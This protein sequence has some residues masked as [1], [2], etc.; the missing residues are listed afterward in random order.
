MASFQIFRRKIF[1]ASRN[2]I[3]PS[4]EQAETAKGGVCE[5]VLSVTY[6]KF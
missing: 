5:I 1:A 2:P 3:S 6:A 4:I